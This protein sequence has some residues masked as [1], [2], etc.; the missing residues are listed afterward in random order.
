[1]DKKQVYIYAWRNNSKRETLYKR[2]MIVIAR[3]TM[4]SCL[5]QF[6]DN[7]QREVVSRNAIRKVTP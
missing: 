4:N 3:G 6:T 1:M 7:G 5:V 2:E